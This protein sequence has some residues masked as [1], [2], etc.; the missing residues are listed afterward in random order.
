[1]ERYGLSEQ[2]WAVLV[3]SVGIIIAL[4]VLFSRNDIFY[5]LIVDWSILGILLKR[6]SDINTSA[7]SIIIVSIVGLSVITIGIIVQL[8]RR[9][10]IY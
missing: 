8:I 2:F 3:I 1:M 7:Q 9:K 6:S 4:A 5:G 10:K